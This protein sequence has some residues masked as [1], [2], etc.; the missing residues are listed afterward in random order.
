MNSIN[1]NGNL[2]ATAEFIQLLT[3]SQSRV[4]AYILSLVFDPDQAD[5]VLQQTNAILWEKA[6]EFEIGTNFIA[7]SFRIAYYQVLAHRK[8]MQRDQ[9]IFDDQL[10]GDLAKVSNQNDEAFERRQRLMRTCLERLNDRQRDLIRRRYSVGANV[11]KVAAEVG[12]TVNAVK[13]SLF[14]ARRNLIECVGVNL[15]KE[16]DNE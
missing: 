16:M 10:I 14:R 7:W 13:Q 12:S 9:L 4:Y 1:I 15:A 6:H 2:M 11:A 5:D 3:T 8:N